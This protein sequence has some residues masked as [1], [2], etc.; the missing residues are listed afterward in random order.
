MGVCFGWFWV[1]RGY[2]V[3]VG[4][5]GCG[6]VRGAYYGVYVVVEVLGGV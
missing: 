3:L 2:F 6:G 4:D 5:C 1:G